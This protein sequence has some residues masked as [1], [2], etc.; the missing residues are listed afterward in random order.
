MNMKFNLVT[1]ALL[2]LVATQARAV[3]ISVKAG[4]GVDANP[5]RLADSFDPQQQSY[6]YNS[7]RVKTDS[8]SNWILEAGGANWYFQDLETADASNFRLF[9]GYK[10]KLLDNKLA[11]T[12]G[13]KY[14][15]SDRTYVSRFSG[16]VYQTKGQSAADRYDSSRFTPSIDLRYRLSKQ[17]YLLFDWEYKTVGYEDYTTL[18]LSNLDYN[19]WQS[20]AGW[21]F[22]VDKNTRHQLTGKF[23]SREYDN[24]LARGLDGK[25]IEGLNSVY[26][27]VGAEYKLR[28]KFNDNLRFSL[29]AD[30]LIR[31][32]NAEGYYDTRSTSIRADI[33]H[34]F[35]ENW[36]Y[37]LSAGYRSLDYDRDT[38]AAS[39]GEV[40]DELPNNRGFNLRAH[41]EGTLF[42]LDTVSTNLYLTSNY[43]QYDSDTAAYQYDRY[44]LETGIRIRL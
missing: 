18:G 23:R 19:Q 35:S 31:S 2:T 27:Y 36:Y 30:M 21:L 5:H 42:K 24:K 41:F 6:L 34:Q 7:Y 11:Y 20:Q 14:Q 17:H 40:D 33:R 32:D 39:T 44:K 38:A 1:V 37:S 8:R 3:D 22:R 12:V 25:T 15:Q 13:L 16:D 4:V 29:T 43:Y 10:D 9:G 28:H 26:D